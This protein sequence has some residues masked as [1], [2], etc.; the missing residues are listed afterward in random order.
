M[1]KYRKVGKIAKMVAKRRK[2]KLAPR[3]QKEREKL[4]AL[5]RS[6]I[7]PHKSSDRLGPSISH[8]TNL[9]KILRKEGL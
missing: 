2:V 5:H 7:G 9:G 6:T 4:V 3:S 8:W 1:G